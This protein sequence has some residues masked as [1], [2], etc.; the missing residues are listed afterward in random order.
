MVW[1]TLVT[2]NSLFRSYNLIKEST[3]FGRAKCN[4]DC[5]LT[6]EFGTTTA[7]ATDQARP[8]FDG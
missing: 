3:K 7:I 8:S 5:N 4:V 1:A 6:E 2:E